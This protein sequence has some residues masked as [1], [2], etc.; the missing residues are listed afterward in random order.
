[1]PL[2][3]GPIIWVD[4]SCPTNGDGTTDDCDDGES[5]PFNDLH[6][7][8]AAAEPGNTVQILQGTGDYVTN[9]MG[10]YRPHVDGGFHIEAPMGSTDPITIRSAP[11]HQPRFANCAID[12]FENYCPNPTF[13]A[14]GGRIVFDD[15]TIQ[16]GI[17]IRGDGAV[18]RS[19][20]SKGYEPQGDGNIGAIKVINPGGWE[21]AHV[22]PFRNNYFH[23]FH[24]LE[25][26]AFTGSWIYIFHSRD[27]VIEYNT[28]EGFEYTGGHGAL[29]DKHSHSENLIFRYNLIIDGKAGPLG[30]Q[31]DFQS[32]GNVIHCGGDTRSAMEVANGDQFHNTVVDCTVGLY[33]NQEDPRYPE[34]LGTRDG[35]LYNNIFADIHDANLRRWE[36]WDEEPDYFTGLERIDFNAYTP[37]R[38]FWWM[39]SHYGISW[40]EWQEGIA[41]EFGF[42]Q[43]SAELVC[44]FRDPAA[45]DYRLVP[46]SV[47]T[48]FGREGGVTTGDPVELGA[49]AVTDCVGHL[50]YPGASFIPYDSSWRAAALQ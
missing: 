12:D 38:Y 37:G 20:L 45:H 26:S 14:R 3:S 2:G 1:M 28:F 34:R 49:F 47:C 19:R 36:P 32:Y 23:D 30:N 41:E 22:G 42:D 4:N 46:G 27:V 18:T 10:D 48:S 21:T 43:N 39:H 11:G 5:G 25:T 40:Q 7:A 24:G 6:L 13:T 35:E 31:T 33:V 50:C 9:H 16:G 29:V 8:L 44:E 15:L 17:V